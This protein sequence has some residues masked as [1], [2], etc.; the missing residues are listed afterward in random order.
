MAGATNL[1]VPDLHRELFI[2][3]RADRLFVATVEEHASRSRTAEELQERLRQRYPRAVVRAQ[4]LS[5]PS[6]RWYVYRD[7]S[8]IL[9]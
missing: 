3:P 5:G 1:W 8:W 4:D 9:T 2:N 6:S 7:G